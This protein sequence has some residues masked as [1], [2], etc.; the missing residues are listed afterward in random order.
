[1]RPRPCTKKPRQLRSAESRESL[2]QGRAHQSGVHHQMASPE[3]VHVSSA[4]QTEHGV[5]VRAC[6]C[7]TTV[8][9]KEDMNLK[10]S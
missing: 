4:I 3:N 10:V 7:K 6:V 1:M 8:H 9:E 2:L 5:R